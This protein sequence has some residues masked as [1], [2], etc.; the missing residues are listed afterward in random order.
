MQLCIISIKFQDCRPPFLQW[1]HTLHRKVFAWRQ[2]AAGE[3]LDGVGGLDSREHNGWTK[4]SAPVTATRGEENSQ[5]SDIKL[6]PKYTTVRYLPVNS[7]KCIRLS[8]F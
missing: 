4:G 7:I 5:W 1:Y 3:I 8:D 2:G 6:N